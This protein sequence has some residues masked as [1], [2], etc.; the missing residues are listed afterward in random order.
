VVVFEFWAD[1]SRHPLQSFF[2]G[3]TAP[4]AR[5]MKKGFPLLPGPQRKFKEKSSRFKEF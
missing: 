2:I 3:L 5:P 1:I 4:Q